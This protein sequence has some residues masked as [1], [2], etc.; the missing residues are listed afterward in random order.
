[1][2]LLE[3]F[4]KIGV[5]DEASGAMER[6]KATTIAAG[7]LMAKGIEKAASGIVSLGKSAVQSFAE[8]EQL[9]GGVETLFGNSADAVMK[10]A[11]NA[12]KTSGLSANEYM[13][14]V[15]G[16]SASLIQSVGGDTE[17][18]ANI[19]D[20]A[21]TDMA[22]NANKMGTDISMI[23]NAYQGFAKQNYTMLDNLKLGY[24]GTKEE[25]ERLLADA[26]KISGIKYDISSFADITEAIHVMQEEM[27]IAGATA[28]EAEST[29]SGSVAA[30]KAAWE[31][32]VVGLADENANVDELLNT[33]L[34][35]VRT[36]G[37]NLL[38]VIE[39]VLANVGAVLTEHGPEF[40]VKG[41][42]M[43]GNL[44][45]GIIEA[46]PS[47]ISKVP[48]IVQAFVDAFE[49]K[50]PVFK[51]IGSMIVRGIWDGISALGLWLWDNVSG[52]FGDIV[53]GVKQ[54]LGIRSPS[55]VFSEI[56]GNMALGV[57]AGWS[58][59]YG[60]VKNRI[61][62][63][64]DF[65]SASVGFAASGVG[66]MSRAVASGGGEIVFE[67][68]VYVGGAVVAR[69][70]YKFNLAENQRRGTS[71]VNV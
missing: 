11:D 22:D 31:N 13:T 23:Q 46:L 19:A 41:A 27:G 34:E 2:N 67:A 60:A 56:G 15:T 52:F 18:A 26:E 61:E 37:G 3:T 4:V 62:S 30:M 71:L 44:I 70:Q 1:M 16:F 25:M 64:L 20:Q 35:S 55:R 69:N 47:L 45:V 68:P 57:G 58:D 51:E 17:K 7:Q 21:I 54:N 50:G 33:F 12:F 36:V 9:T 14:T 29:I 28:A 24:G 40:V 49:G 65:G 10:Y 63:G 8:Y 5:Q 32:L 42:E 38:P 39:N 6:V 66:G 53:D 48:E 59:E 43:L